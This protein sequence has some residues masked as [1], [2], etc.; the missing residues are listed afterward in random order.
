[1]SKRSKLLV[2]AGISV[3][4]GEGHGSVR[5]QAFLGDQFRVVHDSLYRISLTYKLEGSVDPTAVGN[6]PGVAKVEREGTPHGTRLRIATD[7]ST[8]V[9]PR[10]CALAVEHGWKIRELKPQR[11]TLEDLFVRITEEEE[12]VEVVAE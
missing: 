4:A 3:G 5:S 2:G 10:L 8:E 7:G 6:L 11:H 12:P 9:T 1:M